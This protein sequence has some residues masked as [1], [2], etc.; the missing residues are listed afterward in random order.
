MKRV[1][2]LIVMGS[3]SDASKA[4]P[5]IA[6]LKEFGVALDARVCSAHRSPKKLA[7]LVAAAEERGC[8]VFIALAGKAAHLPGVVASHTVKP[9]IGVPIDT[10][11]MGLDSLLSIAQMPPGVPV[12]TVGVDAANNAALLAVQM[13]A[14]SDAK[15]AKRLADYKAALSADVAKQNADAR[16]KLR[17]R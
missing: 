15:L 8:R 10:P 3:A 16:K 13:L 7:A 17:V 14:L 2:V 9:V 1:D 6:V 4:E 12:A 5:A 11:M